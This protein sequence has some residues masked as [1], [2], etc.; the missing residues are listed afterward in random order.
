MTRDTLSK[1]ATGNETLT[2]TEASPD[3]VLAEDQFGDDAN[4]TVEK[5]VSEGHVSINV[6]SSFIDS[7]SNEANDGN[8]T[9]SLSSSFWHLIVTLY[10]PLLVLWFRRT[11]FGSTYLFRTL[12]IGQFLRLACIESLSEWVTEKSPSWLVVLC[13]PTDALMGSSATAGKFAAGSDPH[14]WPPPAFTA[15]ALFTIFT[16]VVHPDGLTWIMLGKIR[17]VTLS[18][19]FE[20]LAKMPMEFWPIVPCIRACV[21]L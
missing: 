9:T 2:T 13:H 5:G 3:S 18:R 7:D 8:S 6:T 12:I 1:P 19:G 14:A 17:Y 11:M 4:S 21:P 20:R 16:L 15:L 10:L